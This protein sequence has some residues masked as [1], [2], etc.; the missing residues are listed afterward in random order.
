MRLIYHLAFIIF[1]I[2]TLTKTI[3]YA[4]YEI[5][6]QNNK[7][8]GIGVIVFSVLVILFSNFVIMLY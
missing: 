1:S 5:K 7:C 4:I 2:F 6:T 8:G 3:F